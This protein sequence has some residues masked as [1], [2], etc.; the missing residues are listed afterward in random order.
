M[1]GCPLEQPKRLVRVR[2]D[3]HG[4]ALPL[5]QP[6]GQLAKPL[7]VLDH[8][9]R[10]RPGARPATGGGASTTASSAASARGKY[11]LNDVPLPTSL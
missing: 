5:Q 2:G 1:D 7:R 8:E 10:L 11:T 4:V 6:L 3:Q 9:H